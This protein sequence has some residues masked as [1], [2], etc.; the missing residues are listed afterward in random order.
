MPYNIISESNH[1]ANSALQKILFERLQTT[2]ECD[3][4]NQ[5]ASHIQLLI[6]T[7]DVEQREVLRQLLLAYLPIVTDS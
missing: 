4:V 7:T 6:P 2:K 3:M 1:V 5:L